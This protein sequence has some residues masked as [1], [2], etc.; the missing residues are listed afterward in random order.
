MEESLWKILHGPFLNTLSHISQWQ[1][2]YCLSLAKY[3]SYIIN[4][5]FH[6]HNFFKSAT[7][8]STHTHTHTHTQFYLIFAS[9]LSGF[10]IFFV[11]IGMRKLKECLK[12]LVK[13]YWFNMPSFIVANELKNENSGSFSKYVWV[14]YE[15]WL[16]IDDS[17]NVIQFGRW[18]NFKRE[19]IKVYT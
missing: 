17:E 14:K 10:I 13:I 6:K 1:N 9:R 2:I 16:L 18:I 7:H 8:M 3:L 5:P 15:N 19:I 11:L 12:T 4:K